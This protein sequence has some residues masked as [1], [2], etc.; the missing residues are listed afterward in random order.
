MTADISMVHVASPPSRK[1]FKKYAVVVVTRKGTVIWL[2]VLRLVNEE[3]NI[4][5][6]T[7][8]PTG[9]EPVFVLS[10]KSLP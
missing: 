8:L 7:K 1:P 10:V 5:P 4:T 6:P 9:F 3:A 2:M